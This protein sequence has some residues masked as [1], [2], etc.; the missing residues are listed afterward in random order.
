MPLPPQP[1]ADGN[2]ACSPPAS[3]N[4]GTGSV[5]V[6]SHVCQ[7]SACVSSVTLPTLRSCR[8]LQGMW[9][10]GKRDSIGVIVSHPLSILCDTLERQKSFPGR[11]LREDAVRVTRYKR[12]VQKIADV[13]GIDEFEKKWGTSIVSSV[14]KSLTTGSSKG[15]GGKKR[16]TI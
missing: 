13:G 7:T 16:R 12:A 15:W 14:Y 10:R 2:A 8:Q 11:L 3:V 5:P 6:G 9:V 1:Q 4:R